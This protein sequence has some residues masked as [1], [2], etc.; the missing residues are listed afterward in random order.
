MPWQLTVI[1][2]A[3]SPNHHWQCHVFFPSNKASFKISIFNFQFLNCLAFSSRQPH[4]I[5]SKLGHSQVVTQG[6]THQCL[7]T[8]HNCA[9]HVIKNKHRKHTY[10]F[11][12]YHTLTA[13]SMLH[14]TGV[15]VKGR[16]VTPS[17]SFS[18]RG[19]RATYYK[20]NIRSQGPLIQTGASA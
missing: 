9:C 7:F 11:Q 18:V 20:T 2:S 3:T 17:F 6:G 13:N 19:A 12:V 5:L 1:D 10:H 4:V 16:P 15:Q 8:A 14:S